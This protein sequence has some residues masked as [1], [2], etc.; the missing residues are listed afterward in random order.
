MSLGK[1]GKYDRVD[2]L[3]HGV[4]GIV[5][6]AW[7]TFLNK[8]VALKEVDILSNDA[9]RFLEEARVMDRLN[10]PNIIHVNGVDRIDGHLVIDMEYVQGSNL[11]ELLRQE[12]KLP[13]D[14][15]IHIVMQVL[16]ALSYANS[17]HVVHRDIKPANILISNGDT[18]KLGDFGL[19][20]ILSTNSFAGGAGTYAY[21]APEDFDEERKSDHQ[22]DIWSVGVTFYEMLTG[23]RPFNVLNPRD[24]FAWRRV[25][26][27]NA[28]PSLSGKL[29][30][31]PPGLEAVVNRALA[32]EKSAR[33]RTA[34]EFRDD[35]AAIQNGKSP[36]FAS[37]GNRPSFSYEPMRKSVLLEE[38][39]ASKQSE[40]TLPGNR[41]SAAEDDMS[42]IACVPVE[43][44]R[45]S[46]IFSRWFHREKRKIT[47]HVSAEPTELNF[48]MVRKGEQGVLELVLR[49]DG[50]GGKIR[51]QV[52]SMPA[53][54][55]V[56]PVQWRAK[57]QRLKVSALADR[58]WQTGQFRDTLRIQT[59]AGELDIPVQLSAVKA[60]VSY[61]RIAWWFIPLCIMVLLPMLSV[62][63]AANLA[64][65]KYLIPAGALGSLLLEA[66]FLLVIKEAELGIGERIAGTAFLLVTALLMGIAA[67]FT[68]GL[69]N[70][71]AWNALPYTGLPLA[72]GLI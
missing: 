31:P 43:A 58:T 35:L 13:P 32:K 4:S 14:R 28:L 62:S 64:N 41:M 27:T 16:D 30:I 20:Q 22:S 12:G 37:S 48:G 50:E 57:K 61:A 70:P 11:L 21:M 6:L 59:E 29:V 69:D 33:Y 17:L 51:G 24:P 26:F 36:I 8:Q 67:R 25:L 56:E 3:G 15:A 23:E 10:H 53:W 46:G 7:D 72:I 19:A 42:T 45:S 71:D 47:L 44:P 52:I 18:V 66:M 38:S 2:V 5:Y 68:L 39:P 65:V 1:L 34:S 40:G 54:L 9:E 49:S 63:W 60:R 55:N